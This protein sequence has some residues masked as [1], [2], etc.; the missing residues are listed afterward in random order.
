MYEEQ[1]R[2][3]D[4]RSDFWM[5]IRKGPNLMDEKKYAFDLLTRKGVRIG[6]GTIVYDTELRAG[7]DKYIAKILI[8]VLKEKRVLLDTR[9]ISYESFLD[10]SDCEGLLLLAKV[11]GRVDEGIIE[12]EYEV[13][14][15]YR[16]L[17]DVPVFSQE[18]DIPQKV[19]G[20]DVPYKHSEYNNSIK[21]L[22]SQSA[23]MFPKS[24][25]NNE[26]SF[27]E[28]IAD[29][30]ICKEHIDRV[31][32]EVDWEKLSGKKEGCFIA[33]VVYGGYDCSEVLYLRRV[34]DEILYRS[35]GGRLFIKFYY[36]WSPFVARLI[37]GN[38]PILRFIKG[39]IDYLIMFLKKYFL[40]N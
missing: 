1:G 3:I 33:T 19:H 20:F 16:K 32:E 36:S 26:D 15:T 5:I 12:E 28:T 21:I 23:G 17:D 29:N 8:K 39:Y 14:K 7:D 35:I 13:K 9:T 10:D 30:K 37:S 4:R 22:N 24:G 40:K 18:R 11:K 31:R 2:N 38:D 34:R 6:P 25:Y 27:T